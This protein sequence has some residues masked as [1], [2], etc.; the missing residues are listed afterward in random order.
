MVFQM[1]V[2]TERHLAVELVNQ[3]VVVMETQVVD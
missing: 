2:L 1:V 3:W